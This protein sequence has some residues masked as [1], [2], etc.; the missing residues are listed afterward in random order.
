VAGQIF[1]NGVLLWP[2]APPGLGVGAAAAAAVQSVLH[3]GLPAYDNPLGA[4][5]LMV[6]VCSALCRP[7]PTPSGKSP[8]H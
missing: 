2:L 4:S 5:D 7:V 3:Q 6:A 1:W 8:D